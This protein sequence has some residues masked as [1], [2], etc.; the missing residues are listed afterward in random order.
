MW[1][2]PMHFFLFLKAHKKQQ[3]DMFMNEARL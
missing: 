3:A 2:K 1:D